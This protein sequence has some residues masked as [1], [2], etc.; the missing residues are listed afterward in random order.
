MKIAV[1]KFGMDR[2]R[3][4]IRETIAENGT[5]CVGV[6]C[7]GC[8]VAPAVIV[9]WSGET[10]CSRCALH[11]LRECEERWGTIYEFATDPIYL[12]QGLAEYRERARF[13]RELMAG[14][15]VGIQAELAGE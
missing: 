15:F 5:P 8:G 3:A 12:G 9:E 4:L 2:G 10:L 1:R 14:V 7:S 6:L 13:D 11:N